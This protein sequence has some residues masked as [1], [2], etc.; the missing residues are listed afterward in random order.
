M[1]SLDTSEAELQS[2][3]D[4]SNEVMSW[5]GAYNAGSQYVGPEL[6]KVRFLI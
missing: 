4:V 3:S 1:A 2:A 5:S 6:P